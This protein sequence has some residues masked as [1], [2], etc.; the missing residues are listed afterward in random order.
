MY[1]ILAGG[2]FY[3]DDTP[4]VELTQDDVLFAGDPEQCQQWIDEQMAKAAFESV[5]PVGDDV[6]EVAAMALP[7]GSPQ[8]YARLRAALTAAIH[9]ICG[10]G[11]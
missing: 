5:L 10:R 3:N 2:V 11:N 7:T 8:G 1:R 4:I 6:V 9:A